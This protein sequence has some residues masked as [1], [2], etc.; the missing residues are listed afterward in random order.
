MTD[1]S[2]NNNNN[3]LV[4]IPN[5]LLTDLPLRPSA[6]QWWH[7]K[8]FRNTMEVQQGL[9]VHSDGS[10]IQWAEDLGADSVGFLVRTK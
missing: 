7:Q 5:V 3:R 9:Q 1:H 6:L 4:S 8:G 2:K 10:I